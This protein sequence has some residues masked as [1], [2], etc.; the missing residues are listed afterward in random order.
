[1]QLNIFYMAGLIFCQDGQNSEKHRIERILLNR[2][3]TVNHEI[4]EI[5]EKNVS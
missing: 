3:N 4:H 5:H 2:E 1:M